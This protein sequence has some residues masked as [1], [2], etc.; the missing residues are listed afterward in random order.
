MAF[1]LLWYTH[2]YTNQVYDQSILFKNNNLS[3]IMMGIL[4]PVAD[5]ILAHQQKSLDAAYQRSD[6]L[7]E[8]RDVLERWAQYVT[9]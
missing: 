7:D 6:L 2:W 4:Q 9:G 5:F 8:R 3:E 1:L